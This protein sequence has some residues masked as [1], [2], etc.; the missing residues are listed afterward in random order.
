MTGWLGR[1]RGQ[2][3]AFL[4]GRDIDPVRRGETL[5]VDEFLALTAALRDSGLLP[6]P[7]SP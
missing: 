1:D 6:A 3:D 2:I 5:T 7:S 4:R